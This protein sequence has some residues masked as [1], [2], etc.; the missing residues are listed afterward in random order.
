[1]QILLLHIL[2][3]GQ[4]LSYTCATHKVIRALEDAVKVKS[5]H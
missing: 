3:H 5:I 2:L 4:K 1:M